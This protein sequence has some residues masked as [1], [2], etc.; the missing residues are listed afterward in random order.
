M[1]DQ[2]NRK[3]EYMRISITDKCNFSCKYC[4]PKSSIE[5]PS[6]NC[7]NYDDIL[8]ICRLAVKTGITRFKVTGGEPLVRKDCSLFIKHLKNIPGV[9]QVT[10]TTNGVLLQQNL[11]ALINAGLD[12]VNISLDTTDDSQ[13][14]N[15]TGYKDNGAT[16]ILKLLELCCQKGLKCKINCVLMECNKDDAVELAKIAQRLPVDVRFIE[17]MPI[18]N[19]TEETHVNPDELLSRLNGIWSDLTPIKEKLG[20]GPAHYYSSNQLKGKI[21]FIDA[22]SHKFCDEC[23]RIRLTSEGLLKPCLCYDASVDLGK[24]IKNNCTDVELLDAIQN[25]IF[26]K[27][28]SHCFNT[29]ENITEHKL[30]SSIG[31]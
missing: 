23:N 27:P 9:E 26:N 24:M 29:V 2:Y 16:K 13:F 28:K 17:V 12:A 11:E 7:L 22:V 20:N 19:G 3:I 6:E 4:N 8:R 5:C 25:S 18:G 10:L 1:I 15:I 21:G 31:G 30:M 14:E